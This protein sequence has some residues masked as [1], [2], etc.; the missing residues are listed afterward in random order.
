MSDY[1]RDNYTLKIIQTYAP[2]SQ[3]SDEE[4]ELF[5]DDI[6]QV[7]DQENTKYALIMGDFNVKVGKTGTWRN[8]VGKWGVGERNHRRELLVNLK[9][10]K[11]MIR[12]YEHIYFQKTEGR[13]P[14]WTWRRPNGTTKNESDFIITDKYTT[15][16]NVTIQTK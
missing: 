6:S 2:I 9:K 13:R 16:K 15:V 10:K 8:S 1:Q 7:M 5:Y 14:T 4:I 3:S 11:N 12:E